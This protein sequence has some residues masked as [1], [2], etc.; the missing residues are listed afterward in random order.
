MGQCAES[1]TCYWPHLD[2]IIRCSLWT[3][4][5][6]NV[7]WWITRSRKV[8]WEEAALPEVVQEYIPKE[9]QNSNAA[10]VTYLAFHPNKWVQK[11]AS[12]YAETS[13]WI[14]SYASCVQ[15]QCADQSETCKVRPQKP[16]FRCEINSRKDLAFGFRFGYRKNN[17]VNLPWK[18][19]CILMNLSNSANSLTANRYHILT[20]DKKTTRC[21][22]KPAKL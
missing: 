11:M 16:R 13:A 12:Y 21:S 14:N 10:S 6:H 17:I 8:I 1:D 19:S 2:S 3:S 15:F 20:V 18:M 22:R 4:Q 9:V 5:Q 7:D